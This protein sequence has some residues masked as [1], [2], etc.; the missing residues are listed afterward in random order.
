MKFEFTEI[1]NFRGAIRGMRNIVF[2]KNCI[3][4]NLKK[5]GINLKFLE[6]FINVEEEKKK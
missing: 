2:E 5:A 1:F 3:L 4:E 6:K